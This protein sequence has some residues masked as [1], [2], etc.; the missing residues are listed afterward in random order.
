MILFYGTVLLVSILFSAFWDNNMRYCIMYSTSLSSRLAQ[1]QISDA[2]DV[3]QIGSTHWH[4]QKFNFISAQHTKPLEERGLVI[5]RLEIIQ[6]IN[7]GVARCARSGVLFGVGHYKD[8][9]IICLIFSLTTDWLTTRTPFD[10]FLNS[11]VF[12]ILW[13]FLYF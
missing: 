13:P 2:S 7:V 11:Q 5:Q 10:H 1:L 9:H 3:N 4:W 8:G 12:S 6:I